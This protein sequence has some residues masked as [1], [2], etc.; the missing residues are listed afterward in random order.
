MKSINDTLK[1]AKTDKKSQVTA[2]AKEGYL[3][4]FISGK[5][6]KAAP[7]EVEAVQPFAQIL[8]QDYGYPIEH[9]QTRPQWH[10]KTSPSD[11]KKSYPIDIGVFAGEQH[12]DD[13]LEIVVECKKK[14]R[15]DGKD[16]L[17]DYMRLSRARVGVWFNG[18]ERLFL[19]KTENKGKVSFTEIPNIPKFGERL[20]DVG[21][22]KRKDLIP[23]HN[24]KS[25]F[26][27]IRNYLAANATGVTRDEVFAQQ[28]INLVFCKIYD[29]RFTKP[30]DVVS[31]RAGVDEKPKD[32]AKRI[33][34]LFVHV[35]QKYSDVIEAEDG[36]IIDDNTLIYVVGEMQLYCL[37]DSDRDAIADAFETFIGPSLKGGQGQFFTPRNVVKLTVDL[38]DPGVGDRVV[39]PA[40]GSG[41][42]L[43]ESIKY[44]WR[45]IEDRAV[46]YSWPEAELG[47]EKQEVAIKNF[48]GVDKDRFLSKVAKAYMAIIGDGRGGIFCENTL[49][50][51]TNW[52]SSQA[53]E[54]IAHNN[55]DVIVTNPPFG[56]K[57][58]ID[59]EAILKQYDLGY[60]WKLDKADQIYKKS[61]VLQDAQSPQILFVEKC[62]NLLKPGGR[63]GIILPE[64]MICNPSHR[65]IIQFLKSTA[66]ITAVV[67][68]PEEL[69]QPYTHAKTC[70]VVL[71]KRKKGAELEDHEIFMAVAKWCGH[72][73]R[74]IS[75]PKD[76]LPQIL[77]NF[78]TYKEHGKLKYD[79]LG[80]VVNESEIKDNVYLPKY[81]NPEISNSLKSLK[82]SHD[83][84]SVQ[85]LVD[86]GLL[87]IN[88]GHE[89]GKL[90]YGTGRI[91]F[92]RTSD[93]ANW[94]IKLDPKHG[95]SREIYDKYSEV[96]DVR[97]HD[98]FMVRDG[99]YLVG[100]CAIVSKAD[101]EIVYQSHVFKIRSNDH[102]KLHPFLLLAALSSP[103]V[104]QQVFSKRFTQD[105]IDTLGA[106]IHELL[107]PIPKNNAEK[108]K[109]IDDVRAVMEHKKS[110]RELT[111]KTVL[112][113]APTGGLDVDDSFLSVLK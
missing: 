27:T 20:E 68:M 36:L 46:E 55:F 64:S 4:D 100:T 18:V 97:E 109:I 94:E 76:D 41:G 34:E 113:I 107:L 52:T 10:V 108:N 47:A 8:V 74:G 96:Q 53:A 69:F 103:I 35:Q 15:T 73:S 92:I 90:A 50:I 9:L 70:L 11:N 25:V 44:V 78:E 93:I 19:K 28:I 6:I 63:M 65:F 42:F 38:V 24:L 77:A 72:D 48:R 71:E 82:K 59:S 95:L 75:I 98:I 99:T 79:H 31:F 40:C 66:S 37:S 13:N 16:Q 60:K 84:M 45:K 29:E 32:V 104:K 87:T 112:G 61:A 14:S 26:R 3:I 67:S 33:R 51:P 5:E 86:D 110:A 91:P 105:I 58:K 106:R 17:E 12:N 81:Y 39:D 111:R 54:Q 101:S 56:K 88:T 2:D 43:V 30:D 89:V 1:M 21:L 85:S 102:E 62:I 80:F 83:L 23:A 57:L 49:D 7:E 22:Y